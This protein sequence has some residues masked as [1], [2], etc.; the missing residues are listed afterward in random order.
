VAE[1]VKIKQVADG[2]EA[3]RLA[4]VNMD[5][6]KIKAIDVLKVLSGFKPDTGIIKSVTIYPSI[7]S[8]CYLRWL[9]LFQNTFQVLTKFLCLQGFIE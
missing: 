5:W 9:C 8:S 1:I 2:E 4:F 7:T 3:S 6:D